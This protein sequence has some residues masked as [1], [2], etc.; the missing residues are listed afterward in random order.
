MS[1]KITFAEPRA[2]WPRVPTPFATLVDASCRE[3]PTFEEVRQASLPLIEAGCTYFVCYG[4]HS[5]AVH[6]FIDD[7][8]A[9]REV[10]QETL[11]GDTIMTTFHH[12]ESARNVAEFF[13][14]CALLGMQ[15][16]LIITREEGQ[17]ASLCER[18]GA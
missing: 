16:A 13:M 14:N 18:S 6:D 15:G 11:Q 4:V 17:W 7:C 3:Q 10:E 12:Q 8:I 5:E 9:V 1:L 2:P